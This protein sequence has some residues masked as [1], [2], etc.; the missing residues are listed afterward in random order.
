MRKSWNRMIALALA[1]AFILALA[2]QPGAWETAYAVG[3]L[4]Q[5]TEE[6]HLCAQ[7]TGL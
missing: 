4:R 5:G 6:R 2:P 7:T 3:L 1:L